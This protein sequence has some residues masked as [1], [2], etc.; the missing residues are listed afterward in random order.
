MIR[1]RSVWVTAIAAAIRAVSVPTTATVCIA[2]GE[3]VKSGLQ[4]ATM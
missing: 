1:L 3:S 4:R 2:A